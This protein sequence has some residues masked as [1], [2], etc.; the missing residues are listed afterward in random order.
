MKAR[1]CVAAWLAAS[2]VAVG[3]GAAQDR[4]AEPAPLAAKALLLDVASAGELRVA[5]G[6]RGIVLIS[7]DGA[8]NWRQ[9]TSVPTQSTL[10]GVF[11]FDTKKGVAVGHDEVILGTAD[12][13]D[14]WDK[15]HYAPDA[16]QPLF[17]VFFLDPLH[18]IAVGA[19]GAYFTTR[20]GGVTW[21]PQKFSA[22]PVTGTAPAP[23]SDDPYADP[24]PE[25]HLNQIAASG[26]RLFIAGESGQLYRSDDRGETW[27]T[28]PSP[29]DGSFFGVLPLDGDVVLAFGLRGHLFRSE[30]AG[31]TWRRIETGT[32]A[33]LTDGVR[34]SGGRVAIV[35]LSGVVLVSEDEGK[36]FQLVQQEDRK[37]LAA[38]VTRGRSALTVVGEGGIKDIV[39]GEAG[40]P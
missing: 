22:A 39:T 12:G 24:P 32:V 28:L 15:V 9:A 31:K 7:D 25:F 38:V 5:V 30:D 19:Y 18:G 33:L 26:G 13:G 23:A 29:Y 35:G 20:D 6:E 8:Q 36:T 34:L 4:P 27:Q 40:T 10:T 37:G 21:S 11:L 14:T 3:Q 1:A 16:Q 2:L 17:D